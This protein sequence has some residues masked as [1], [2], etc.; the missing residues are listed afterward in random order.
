VQ[1]TSAFAL[2]VISVFAT[3]AIKSFLNFKPVLSKGR[4]NT[5]KAIFKA[6]EVLSGIASKEL[7][8]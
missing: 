5:R 4:I 2:H 6:K 7:K 1:G 3:P 8:L